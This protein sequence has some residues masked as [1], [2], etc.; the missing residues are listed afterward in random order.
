ME[1]TGGREREVYKLVRPP[2]KLEQRSKEEEKNPRT[3]ELSK[4][5]GKRVGSI[6]NQV[7]DPEISDYPVLIRIL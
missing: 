6:G 7:R 5:F 2:W 3:A 1:E 4:G